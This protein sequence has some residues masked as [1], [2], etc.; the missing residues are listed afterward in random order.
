MDFLC[1]YFML[2]QLADYNLYYPVACYIEL[3]IYKYDM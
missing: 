1:S 2:N 3:H